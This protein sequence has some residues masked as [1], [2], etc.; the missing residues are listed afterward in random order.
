LYYVLFL[1]TMQLGDRRNPA[2]N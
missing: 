2:R 1:L